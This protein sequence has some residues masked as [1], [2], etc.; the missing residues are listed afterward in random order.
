MKVES[1]ED[2]IIHEMENLSRIPSEKFQLNLKAGFEPAC[3]CERERLGIVFEGL[4][5]ESHTGKTE[6]VLWRKAMEG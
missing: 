2:F 6:K 4:Q 5:L 3:V 1:L